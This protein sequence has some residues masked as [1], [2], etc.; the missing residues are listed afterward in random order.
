MNRRRLGTFAAIG[1]LGITALAG[2]VGAQQKSLKEQLVG[3]WTLV[4]LSEVYPDGRRDNP[5]G[6]ALK[7]FVNFDS[8]GKYVLTFVGAD[9]PNPKGKPQESDRMVVSHFGTYAVD[10]SA[11][12]VTYTAER[13]T[14][15]A[16]D[17][18]ARRANVTLE[19][20]EL[21]QTSAPVTGPQG[22]FTPNLVF[23]RAK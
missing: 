21:R 14:T 20:D 2:S 5:W 9:L 18:L 22:T 11:K 13:A 15:P 6:P 4:S 19:G 1:I 8:S 7:G 17:G 23:R 16:F 3:T 10:E 12:T